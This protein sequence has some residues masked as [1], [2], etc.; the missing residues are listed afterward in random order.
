MFLQR[1]LLEQ[2]KNLFIFKHL[3]VGKGTH[4]K[5]TAKEVSSSSLD[6]FPLRSFSFR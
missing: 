6:L 1:C 5:V 3:M 2:V 4:N